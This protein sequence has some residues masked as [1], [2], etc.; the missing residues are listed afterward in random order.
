M[1][2]RSP[3]CCLLDQRHIRGRGTLPIF[4]DNAHPRHSR[5]MTHLCSDRVTHTKNRPCP[6]ARSE[7]TISSTPKACKVFGSAGPSRQLPVCTGPAREQHTTQLSVVV[8]HF[9][10]A[11][12]GHF[13]R[14]P[15]AHTQSRFPDAKSLPPRLFP[16]VR[17]FTRSRRTIR[18]PVTITP[19][20]RKRRKAPRLRTIGSAPSCM[21]P[22]IASVGP[23]DFV[24]EGKW[25]NKTGRRQPILKG[26]G[27]RPE[28]YPLCDCC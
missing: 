13:S 26:F 6:W 22:I 23:R 8:G 15:K 10:R 7:Q 12:Y 5:R 14:V 21:R 2:A 25:D 28:T 17:Q 3:A 19:D 1:S 16:S 4:V 27:S 11:K 9:W 18:P 24:P 20:Y